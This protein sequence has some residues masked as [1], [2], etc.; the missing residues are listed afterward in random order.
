MLPN[1][2][3]P[4]DSYRANEE[5]NSSLVLDAAERFLRGKKATLISG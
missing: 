4:V 3:D 2:F 5:H 1:M